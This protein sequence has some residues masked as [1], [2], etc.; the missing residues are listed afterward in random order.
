[1]EVTTLINSRND[2]DNESSTSAKKHHSEWRSYREHLKRAKPSTKRWNLQATAGLDRTRWKLTALLITSE[3]AAPSQEPHRRSAP[4]AS[5]IQA[6]SSWYPLFCHTRFLVLPASDG[7]RVWSTD[8][9]QLCWSVSWLTTQHWLNV[10][11][12]LNQTY[13]SRGVYPRGGWESNLPH[14]LKWGGWGI[15]NFN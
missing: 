5:S 1:V 7:M 9:L 14:F 11:L 2:E 12:F 3:P 10:S 13:Q 4:R 8:I 6:S 15:E